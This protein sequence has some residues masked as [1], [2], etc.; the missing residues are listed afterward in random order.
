MFCFAALLPEGFYD[1][2]SIST[3][4]YLFQV[5]V[6]YKSKVSVKV[7]LFGKNFMSNEVIFCANE[8]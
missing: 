6:T 1:I 3:L 8:K 4:L 5:E 2:K 7:P